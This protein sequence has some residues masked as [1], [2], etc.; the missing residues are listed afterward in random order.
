MFL[1][2]AEIIRVDECDIARNI[3]NSDSIPHYQ[4]IWMHSCNQP[5]CDENVDVAKLVGE[6]YGMA[7]NRSFSCQ[8]K[9]K[10]E[11]EVQLSENKY[12]WFCYVNITRKGDG[13]EV[14]IEAGHVSVILTKHFSKTFIFVSD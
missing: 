9:N 5:N 1:V 11:T 10:W 8:T 13:S 6:A 12:I 7:Y 2:I 3:F 4:P 14:Y